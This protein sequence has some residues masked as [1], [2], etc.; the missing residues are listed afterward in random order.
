MYI[1]QSPS[2]GA[3]KICDAITTSSTA[4]FNLTVGSVAT[5]PETAHH[6]IVS[7]NGVI[8]API[9]AFTISGSQIVFN[10]SLT[11][12]D[13]VD[14]ILILGDVMS[15]GTPSDDTVTL[16]KMASGTDGNII[17]YDASGNP[18]AIATGSDGQVLTSAGAGQP[19][20]FEALSAGKTLQVVQTVKT[21]TTS[22]TSTSFADI[23]GMTVAITPAATSSKILVYVNVHAGWSTNYSASFSLLRGTTQIYMG[24]AS[25]SRTRAF[26]GGQTKENRMQFTAGAVYLDSPSSTSE[27]TYKLQWLAESG[28]TVWLNRDLGNADAAYSTMSASSITVMEIGA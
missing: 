18:V 21:D 15:I 25:S 27:V 1:G 23:S 7:L 10:S 22:T 24:D 20:A 16:A 8:Q 19:P 12:A 17:S 6:C 2:T 28:A 3:Y 4:T 13:V 5:T 26:Y 9:S 11:S 14:F